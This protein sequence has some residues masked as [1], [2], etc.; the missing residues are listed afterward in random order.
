MFQ[1]SKSLILALPVILLLLWQ[2]QNPCEA[3]PGART[4]YSL[5]SL[6]PQQGRYFRWSAPP[7]WRVSETNAGVTLT[8]ADGACSASLATVLRSRGSRTPSA[9]LQWVF[10]HVP[11]YSHARTISA[12]NLPDQRL[13]YQVW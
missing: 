2:G 4:N 8:S 13:S 12:K 6:Q 1:S 5:S 9:F 3:E 10:A 11:G 7:G